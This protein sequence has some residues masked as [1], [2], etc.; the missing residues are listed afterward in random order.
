MWGIAK[1][2][3][4]AAVVTVDHDVERRVSDCLWGH[5][6][7]HSVVAIARLRIFFASTSGQKYSL[8][9][10]IFSNLLSSRL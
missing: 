6:V 5:C 3:G 8:S 9:L 2:T 1:A 4:A 7:G 10:A